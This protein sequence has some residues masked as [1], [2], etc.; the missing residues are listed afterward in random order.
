MANTASPKDENW[1][2]LVAYLDGE[3]DPRAARQ[4]EAQLSRDP[5]ARAEAESLRKTWE[6]LEYLPRPEPTATFASRTME[7]VSALRPDESRAKR[8]RAWRAWVLRV[9]WAAAILLAGVAGFAAVNRLAPQ[10]VASRA[11]NAETQNLPA[12]RVQQGDTGDNLHFVQQLP[13][14]LREELDQLPAEKRP[15]R[16]A[17]LRRQEH[18]FRAEW[19]VAIRNWD[20]WE[21][22]RRQL[23]SLQKLRPEI[24]A[25]V[26]ESLWPLLSSPEKQRLQET[27]MLPPVFFT[28][29]VE[30]ADKHPIRVPP[31]R[32]TGPARFSELPL[33]VQQAVPQLR[34]AAPPGARLTEGTW[35][36]YAFAVVRYAATQR[37][38]IPR[39]LGPARPEQFAPGVE[40]F[41]KEK[42]I[43]VLTAEE[44]VRLNRA[45]G[46]WPGYPRHVRDLA[47]E[48]KLQVPGMALPGTPG[49]WEPF[50]LQR[51]SSP[52]GSSP[53]ARSLPTS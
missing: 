25:F 16:M 14:K 24:E 52:A 41:I 23:E 46:H 8:D 1:A 20:D 36:D 33:A 7:R 10:P 35:P 27:E 38:R 51:A 47:R 43:P 30:L 4:V 17:E 29:L 13:L 6:M 12:P 11:T 44:K 15:A 40:Q 50:R 3:L 31:G 18:E 22:K 34:S 2:D 49:L 42:L 37:I 28:T 32:T 19:Q 39:A 53:K 48:H 26:K 21:Q 9:G 45:E 5:A